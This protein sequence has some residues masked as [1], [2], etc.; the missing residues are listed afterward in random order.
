MPR[1]M[2]AAERIS[3][4]KV[5]SDSKR[6]T[7]NQKGSLSGL[8]ALFSTKDSQKRRHTEFRPTRNLIDG[9]PACRIYGSASVKK[10]TGNLHIT[11]L[12][13]GYTSHHHTDHSG[14]GYGFSRR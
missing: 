1:H 4:S 13:H 8:Q 14:E 11:T 2:S 9:G 3:A 5:I 6:S 12:G 10:V 7:P